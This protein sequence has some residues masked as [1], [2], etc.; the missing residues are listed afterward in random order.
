MN[1]IS[2]LFLLTFFLISTL[3]FSARTTLA[4]SAT[5]EHWASVDI[6]HIQYH[7]YNQEIGFSFK[8][9]HSGSMGCPHNYVLLR[10]D[11]GT[12]KVNMDKDP[13]DIENM[14][15]MLLFAKATGTQ[16]R[17]GA[18]VRNL[19]AR[20]DRCWANYLLLVD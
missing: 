15:K 19:G 17:F 13:K 4:E 14:Y 10:Y 7:S 11:D 20:G 16:V 3:I 6:H 18:N 2:K 9:P 8:N 12:N 1:F 5:G